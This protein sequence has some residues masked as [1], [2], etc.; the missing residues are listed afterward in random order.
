MSITIDGF[1]INFETGIPES[2]KVVTIKRT[3]KLTDCNFAIN[4]ETGMPES[5]KIVTIKRTNKLTDCNFVINFETGIPES[6][7]VVTILRGNV[8]PPELL[9]SDSET[10]IIDTSRDIIFIEKRIPETLFIDTVRNVK[11]KE[12]F[13]LGIINTKR[14]IEHSEIVSEKY[15]IDTCRQIV[16]SN[17]PQKEIFIVES[18]RKIEHINICSIFITDTKRNIVFTNIPV[19]ENIIIDIKRNIV[20]QNIISAFIFDTKRNIVQSSN[21]VS[22]YFFINTNR[23]IEHIEKVLREKNIIETSR[24]VNIASE[25]SFIPTSRKRTAVAKLYYN[26]SKKLPERIE[27]IP[28]Q[29]VPEQ[30]PGEKPGEK[31]IPPA[32]VKNGHKSIDLTLTSGEWT[33]SFKLETFNQYKIDDRIKIKIQNYE[34]EFVVVEPSYKEKRCLTTKKMIP[35]TFRCTY[36]SE[37]LLYKPT[38]YL[39]KKDKSAND[40]KDEYFAFAEE[41]FKGVCNSLGKGCIMQFNPY[42]T[43]SL[44]EAKPTFRDVTR[45]LFDWT[46]RLPH[47]QI[48]V[49]QR[50][51]TLYAIERGCEKEVIELN[52]YH[53][54]IDISMQKITLLT[55]CSDTTALNVTSNLNSLDTDKDK[56]KYF[57]GTVRMGNVSA[58]YINGLLVKEVHKDGNGYKCNTYAYAKNDEGWLM[59]SK[60]EYNSNMA[61]ESSLVAETKYYY[62]T[63]DVNLGTSDKTYL[64]KEET[65][66]Y[67][68]DNDSYYGGAKKTGKGNSTIHIPIGMDFFCT[69]S[70]ENNE[71][72]G[73]AIGHGAS[74]GY[75]S[76]YSCRQAEKKK[77]QD[78][79]SWESGA[80][81][82][83][84]RYRGD[85]YFPVSNGDLGRIVKD[86]IWLNG[87]T[88]EQVTLIVKNADRIYDF[89]AR[90]NWRG[91]EYYLDK[92]AISVDSE[93]FNQTLTLLRWY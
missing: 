78:N 13:H 76:Q 26:I 87:K 81:Y 67:E 82:L 55:E 12:L 2:E 4:V 56:Q 25:L 80:A 75:A 6:E 29:Q 8:I 46:Q 16:F 83:P 9:P 73:A 58:E 45:Q 52:N 21:R 54:A 68:K 14:Q 51:N 39:S 88:Q 40:K 50:E 69:Q 43:V 10:S 70:Y 59:Y 33:D 32:L 61:S 60:K 23:K 86:I 44:N 18:Q 27:I 72:I 7:K 64:Y 11:Q 17:I 24:K 63:L 5:E 19:R 89:T 91:N 49:F 37:E 57:S 47:R 20:H 3:N 74:A 65:I 1:A 53:E 41:I 66:F 28:N 71:F 30:E 38:L 15:I 34:Q 79:N 42:Y 85:T 93:K 48:N 77:D 92:N 31:P 36:D 62:K 84:G 35:Y 90:Y 22:E